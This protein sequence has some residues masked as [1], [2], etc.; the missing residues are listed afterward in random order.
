M[1]YLTGLYNAVLYVFK[2]FDADNPAYNCPKC[3]TALYRPPHFPRSVTGFCFL[4][5]VRLFPPKWCPRCDYEKT[6]RGEGCSAT[7]ALQT[8][9]AKRTALRDA[10]TGRTVGE[11]RCEKGPDGQHPA[12]PNGWGE[13]QYQNGDSYKGHFTNGKRNMFGTYSYADGKHEYV[14]Q[15]SDGQQEG[16][17]VLR[18]KE[19][20]VPNGGEV[21]LVHA[22]RWRNN[23]LDTDVVGHAAATSEWR[24]NNKG[25][26]HRYEGEYD[27]GEMSGRGRYQICSLSTFFYVREDPQSGIRFQGWFWRLLACCKCGRYLSRVGGVP[28]HVV[29]QKEGKVAAAGA[30]SATRNPGPSPTL[31]VTSG[32][33]EHVISGAQKGVWTP[34]HDIAVEALG[35]GCNRTVGVLP[36][37]LAGLIILTCAS[38]IIA[39]AVVCD[40]GIRNCSGD[41]A[42]APSLVPSSGPSSMPSSMPSFVPSPAVSDVIQTRSHRIELRVALTSGV[43]MEH[44]RMINI[45]SSAVTVC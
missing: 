44:V 4:P 29:R 24:V 34:Q 27:N 15:W 31:K 16:Y 36:T 25:V 19:R 7:F 42:D 17:G 43:V 38:L 10:T 21:T 18:C 8:F 45:Y 13:I 2:Y 20:S 22:G 39:Q 30:S 40:D 28:D 33:S 32:G 1:D 9:A 12:T 41:Q 26:I 23:V 6:R 35:T 37:V 14:G 5:K 11:F 3:G